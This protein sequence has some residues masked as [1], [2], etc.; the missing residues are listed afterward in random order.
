[1]VSIRLACFGFVVLLIFHTVPEYSL[2]F[3][4]VMILFIFMVSGAIFCFG[5]YFGVRGTF[6]DDGIDFSTP[7]TGRK[8]EKWNDL[9]SV[10][11]N[12]LAGWYTLRFE[13]G[14]IVRLSLLLRGSNGVISL[15]KA[16]GHNVR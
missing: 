4:S 6:D 12:P 7:W 1:M 11:A 14:K 15:L 16:R 5:E 13:S 10:A 8:I 2:E 9:V 3:I